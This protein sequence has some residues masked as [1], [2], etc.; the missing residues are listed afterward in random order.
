MTKRPTAKQLKAIEFEAFK[1]L[2]GADYV[3]QRLLHGLSMGTPSLETQAYLIKS[4][5]KDAA[6]LVGKVLDR[7]NRN[8]TYSAGQARDIVGLRL[9]VLF[10]SE[11]PLLLNRFLAF[12]QWSQKPPFSLFYGERLPDCME[13]IIIYPVSDDMDPNLGFF[14]EELEKF[15]FFDEKMPRDDRVPVKVI[16]KQSRYSSIHIVLWANGPTQSV[17]DRIPVEIQL[18]TSLEDV[19]GEIEH[20]LKYKSK[21]SML[22]AGSRKA[23]DRYSREL[24]L[25]HSELENLKLSLDSASNTA[26]FLRRRIDS[27]LVNEVVIK[28]YTRN[29]SFDMNVLK[30]IGLPEQVMTQIQPALN[31]L[32]ELYHR[33]FT[34]ADFNEKF[35]NQALKI[36]SRG[37]SAFAE[38]LRLRQNAT[39]VTNSAD[40]QKIEYHLRM[41]KA[42]CFY[43][44]AVMLH[45]RLSGDG[46]LKEDSEAQ[47]AL[48]QAF[49]Q[50]HG[51]AR[52]PIYA[53]DTVV[54]FRLASAIALTGDHDYALLKYAEAHSE[55]SRDTRL[56]DQHQMRI[57]IPRQYA[58]SLWYAAERAKWKSVELGDVDMFRSLRLKQYLEAMEVSAD[59]YGKVIDERDID[60]RAMSQ[61][62]ENRV[63]A[64]NIVFYA[65]SFLEA[66]GDGASLRKREITPDRLRRFVHE[67]VAGDIQRIP[68][69]SFADTIRKAAR[70]LGDR[71]LAT[72]AATRVLSLLAQ[73]DFGVGLPDRAY[74]EAKAF[75]EE[76][77]AIGNREV[78]GYPLIW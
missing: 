58:F 55:L 30:Y 75:A 20:R 19:W 64:N 21:L 23:N 11:L 49:E 14:L 67:V 1:A 62:E 26:D 57:I 71:E 76:E 15:G 42:L 50:Y 63:T 17:S 28:S 34:Q 68:R 35:L 59:I 70:I 24:G 73:K 60:G 32:M 54:L 33:I 72:L 10:K 29:V 44:T 47:A 6:S 53:K 4:R 65:C 16:K 25:A 46:S 22:P 45:G 18:R 2:S 3:R 51:V 36:L 13:E 37:A 56:V 38:A 69:L 39:G 48:N 43:W 78:D 7:R 40:D 52:L 77:L 74:I 41:E 8:R 5:V 27:D 12:V 61:V 31:E 66:G 9:L